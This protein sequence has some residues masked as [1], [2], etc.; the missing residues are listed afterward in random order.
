[1]RKILFATKYGFKWHLREKQFIFWML[2]FPILLMTVFA[3]AF[4]GIDSGEDFDVR[5]GICPDNAFEKVLE[6]I[7]VFELIRADEDELKSLMD[8]KDIDGY[9]SPDMEIVVRNSSIKANIIVSTMDSIRKYSIAYML[10]EVD[11]IPL[12]ADEILG[13][14]LK[15]IA[16]Y[17]KD[18][19]EY[20]D[21]SKSDEFRGI[22]ERIYTNEQTSNVSQIV[23]LAFFAMVSL[24]SAYVSMN[25]C[26]MI[27][28]NI[29]E[30]GKR[31]SISAYSKGDMIIVSILV[32]VVMGLALDVI[33]LS[34]ISLVL[35]IVA[36]KEVFFSFVVLFAASIYGAGLGAIIGSIK[37]LNDEGKT[38]VLT[39]FF[40]TLAF[41]NGMGG[42][43][44]KLYIDEH[45]A[46][47]NK[48][49]PVN[50][51]NESL[52]RLNIIGSGDIATNVS[53]LLVGAI[54]WFLIASISLRRV[55]YDSL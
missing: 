1:M 31:V 30:V 10:K 55:T 53:L 37:G 19:A 5:L 41:L 34:Y 7:E 54:V 43:S 49:N 51:V 24:Y 46:I 18:F 17:F 39:V 3:V 32:S 52:S 44:I 20:M 13:L 25:Y 2:A 16:V 14:K 35:G 40:M 26:E 36:I 9:I 6:N 4:S 33:M 50:L 48:I 11:D 38:S 29:G 22:T 8:E 23:V 42:Q 27:Q 21:M 28:A 15:D 47:L 45:L 12:S